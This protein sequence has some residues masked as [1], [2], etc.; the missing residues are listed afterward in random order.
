MFAIGVCFLFLGMSL[1]A[2][3]TPKGNRVHKNFHMGQCT[4]FVR[5]GGKRNSC[6]VMHCRS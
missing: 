4:V 3:E 5:A 2:P 1:L 6:M